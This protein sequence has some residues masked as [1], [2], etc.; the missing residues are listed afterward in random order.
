ME[1]QSV[2]KLDQA[3]NAQIREMMLNGYTDGQVRALHYLAAERA[4]RMRRRP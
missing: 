2:F 3:I 1:Q 4:R